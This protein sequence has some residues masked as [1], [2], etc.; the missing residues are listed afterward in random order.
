ML[1]KFVESERKRFII[2]RLIRA[3]PII[4]F[5]TIIVFS[6]LHFSPGNP[7]RIMLGPKATE[8]VVQHL[9][10]EMGLDRPLPVQYITWVANFVRGDWGTSIRFD[11]PVRSL[12][13]S[14]LPVTLIIM[15]LSLTLS[16]IL[17]I[18]MGVLGALKQN[19]IF[20]YSST[21]AALFWR[22]IPSFWLGI[23]FLYFF[24]LRLG[25]FPVGGWEGLI[26]AVLPVLVLGLRLQAIIARLTR[27]SMLNVLN[28]EYIK[29]AKTK[30]L[31]NRTVIIKHALR[32]ALI[33]VTTIVAMRLPWL[34]GGAMVTEQVFNLPGMGRLIVSGVMARDY[35]VVQ[36][37]VLLIAMMVVVANLAADIIY[38]FVDPRIKL[39]SSKG[40]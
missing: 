13:L 34:F 26:T 21:V 18:T 4:L 39:G 30:G 5:A 17:G 25:W 11:Q 20:D 27:S 31:K 33:P 3:I 15:S 36:G 19:S 40:V 35:P 10:R 12:I 24:S 7:A 37:A 2:K 6:I 9:E 32:N 1:E 38:T 16:T 29:T 22:S 28:K 14:R 23:L 8:E